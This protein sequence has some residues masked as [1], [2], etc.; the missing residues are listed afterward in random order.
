MP[1][2]KYQFEDFLTTV[3]ENHSDFVVNLHT[4][5]LKENYKPKITV[6]KSTGLQLAYHQ[7]NIK[8]TAGIIFIFFIKNEKLVLRLYGKNHAKYPDALNDLP[9]AMVDQI[10]QAED[11]V[12]FVNPDKCWKGCIGYDFH[13]KENH[14]Q[15]CYVTG[16]EFEADVKSM[17]YLSRLVES[18]SKVRHMNDI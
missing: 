10:R 1:K 6:T 18:E 15:K 3:H 4:T 9:E 7:P 2:A 16:F 14:Y 13:I 8:T 12:K 11:C 5:M 17:P